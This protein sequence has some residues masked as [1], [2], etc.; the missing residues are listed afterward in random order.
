MQD[1]VNIQAILAILFF[2]LPLIYKHWKG[3]T[4]ELGDV[5][6]C[7][8]ASMGLLDLVI[9]LFYLVVHPAKAFEMAETKQYLAIAVLVI[10][11]LTLSEIHKTF[12][13][14]KSKTQEQAKTE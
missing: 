1:Q 11:Y 10:I 12:G 8:L 14:K 2:I 6:K 7:A 5:I 3:Q 4:V 9:C 13:E